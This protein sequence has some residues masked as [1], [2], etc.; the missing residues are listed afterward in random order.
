MLTAP[1]SIFSVL[2]G[3]D[4]LISI[5]LTSL[6][7]FD[8]LSCLLTHPVTVEIGNP[9]FLAQLVILNPLF[10]NSSIYRSFSSLGYLTIETSIYLLQSYFTVEVFL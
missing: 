1:I 5:N 7:C 4:V 10:L 2:L 6:E 9:F 8:F 3:C